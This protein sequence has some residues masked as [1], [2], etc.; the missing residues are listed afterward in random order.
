MARIVLNL[1]DEDRWRIER[2]VKFGENWRERQRAQTL[3][4]LGKGEFAEDVAVKLGIH[5]RTVGTTRSRW[6]AEGM[7]SLADRPR[8]GAPRKLTSEQVQRLAE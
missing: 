3:V 1:A 2:V 4:L 7:A 8:S 6:L 5:V